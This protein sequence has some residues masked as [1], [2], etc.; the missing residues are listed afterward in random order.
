MADKD[1]ICDAYLATKLN[2]VIGVPRQARILLCVILG[3]V[4]FAAPDVVEKDDLEVLLKRWR[5]EAPHVLI[6]PEAVGQHHGTSA[7]PSD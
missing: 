6:A 1:A 4:R 5:N 2:E 7:L 3:K